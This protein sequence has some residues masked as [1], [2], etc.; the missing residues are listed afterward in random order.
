MDSK[1]MS[2]DAQTGA[3]KSV[4][5]AE[6]LLFGRALADTYKLVPGLILALLIVFV[7]VLVA[8]YVNSSLGFKG[9]L[10]YI[11]TAIVIGLLVG[12]VVALPTS[13]APGVSFCL[14][15]L[16]RLGII[17]M[18]VRLSI[19]DAVRIGAWGVPIVVLCILTGLVLTT[20]FT[21]L[22]R[23]P[24][25][26]GTLMAV[27]TSICGASAIVA[28]APAIGAK[29]QE[30]TYA[31]ANITV[32]GIIAM[33][34]YPYLA[35]VLFA[36]NVV[37]TGL[38]LGT[39][40]HETSQVT[41]GA[42]IYD[43]AFNVTAKPSAT[44][45]AIVIKLVRNVFIAAVIPLMAYVYARRVTSQGGTAS[46]RVSAWKLFPIFILGFVAMAIFRSLG[47]AGFQHGGLAIGIWTKTDWLRGIALVSD[48]AGYALAMAMAG[49]GL[50]T[51]LDTLKGLGIKP[52]YVGLFASLVVGIASVLAVFLLGRFVQI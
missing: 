27:G 3:A 12:N 8:D 36:G 39:A 35:N 1:A 10:S 33:L 29:D 18:G 48:S 43:Q 7:S 15:K 31:V 14:T 49:V 21:R 17:L 47:D 44:D 6:N 24:D 46:A 2:V 19:F 5:I 11:M 38:L 4:S 40:I 45:I 22:L 30:V 41:G 34:V 51:R 37:M 13:I 9:L 28:T 23:L 32:F 20:Y 16:L 50:G 26:L 52:F 25:R 42:L